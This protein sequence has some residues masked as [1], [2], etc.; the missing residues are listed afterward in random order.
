MIKTHIFNDTEYKFIPRKK[1]SELVKN[2]YTENQIYESNTNIVLLTNAELKKINVE[3]L[4]HNY[5]TDVISFII[6]ELPLE[7]EIYISIE[8]AEEQAKEYKVSLTNELLRLVA[9][10]VLHTLGHEDN[11]EKLKQEMHNL[12]N[13]YIEKL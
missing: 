5:E 6:E 2:I 3:F 7:T 4:N 9:H 11:T 1:I 10:G 8:K 12:E 13:Y